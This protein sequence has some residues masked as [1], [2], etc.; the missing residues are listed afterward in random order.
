MGAVVSC[1]QSVFRA[2]GQCIMAVVN[3]IGSII[4][5][6]SPLLSSPLATATLTITHKHDDP[7]LD[8]RFPRPV[9]T[10]RSTPSLD[11][12]AQRTS[13]THHGRKTYFI[14][15]TYCTTLCILGLGFLVLEFKISHIFNAFL[16]DNFPE[17]M[18]DSV[19]IFRGV[20]CYVFDVLAWIGALSRALSNMDERQ[21]IMSK[22]GAMNIIFGWLQGIGALIACGVTLVAFEAFLG[23]VGKLA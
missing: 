1:I 15:A 7:E 9:C 13:I 3:A 2:I 5:A 19:W 23:L 16:N 14:A 20:F 17:K 10:D 22:A 4:M 8:D 18:S 21:E 6:I 12:E 11:L